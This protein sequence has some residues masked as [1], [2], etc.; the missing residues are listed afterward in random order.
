M[1]MKQHSYKYKI[2]HVQLPDSI[3]MLYF[4]IIIKKKVL[5]FQFIN[6]NIPNTK[7]YMAV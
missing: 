4:Q 3:T 6:T 7:K 5:S 2:V 1:K